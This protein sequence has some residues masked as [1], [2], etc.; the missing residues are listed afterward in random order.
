[1]YNRQLQ[2]IRLDKIRRKSF[3]KFELKKTL[4]KS[5]ENTTDLSLSQ[6]HLASYKK[7]LL[8]RSSSI[9]RMV[10]RCTVS[11][12]KYST[13]KKYELSR[14]NFRHHSNEGFLPGLRR[15]SW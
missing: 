15:H 8:P 13:L 1:M 11:G 10:N 7:V 5:I 3:I 14:F 6:K 9:T 2:W 12:R 4:L